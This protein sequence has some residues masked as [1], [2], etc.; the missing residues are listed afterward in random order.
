MSWE[1]RVESAGKNGMPITPSPVR[2]F[3]PGDAGF[4]EDAG[5]YNEPERIEP[6]SDAKPCRFEGCTKPKLSGKGQAYC[7][8]H[9]DKAN[10]KPG[11][12]A[13][14]RKTKR[15]LPINTGAVGTTTVTMPSSVVVA[16]GIQA[17]R[18]K[19]EPQPSALDTQVGGDHYKS[20]KIQPVQFAEAN[21]LSAA[22]FAVVKYVCRHR[23]KGGR[24]DLQKA[25]HFIDLL[26]ELTYGK[27]T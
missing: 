5:H 8:H 12:A 25:R 11:G 10:R 6:M 27:A 2:I 1:Q 13:P 14:V 18:K 15:P 9:A 20:M 17:L 26:E 7:A 4:P 24:L 23:T 3:R 22:E 21:K 19:S 16:A